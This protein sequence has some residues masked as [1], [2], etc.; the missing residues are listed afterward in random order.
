[1]A[2]EGGDACRKPAHIVRPS[3][4]PRPDGRGRASAGYPRPSASRSFNGAATGWPRKAGGNRLGQADGLAFNGAATGWPR[5]A[6]VERVC[7]RWRVP[8]NGA[9]TGWPRKGRNCPSPRLYRDPSMGPRPDGRGRH[10]GEFF[11]VFGAAAFNGAAT[12]WPRKAVSRL[13][14]C[15]TIRPFNGAATGWPRKACAASHHL[16]FSRAFNGAATGWP[17]K[18]GIRAGRRVIGSLQWGRDRM[19]AEG[20]PAVHAIDGDI[21]P[22]MGPRPDGR[23][24]PGRRQRQPAR[25]HAFNGAAT[26]WPRKGPACVP[27]RSAPTTFN[28]A[29]TGWP[30]KVDCRRLGHAVAL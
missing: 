25:L 11:H 27:M 22:S 10:A 15:L 14:P 7:T 2:A 23:G 29:A 6:G 4:G 24:R 13:Q 17:R 1:M 30:R 21:S 20:D 26:G 18:A 3:M 9:A 12:G 19:A 16:S 5:K 8:F 28:G